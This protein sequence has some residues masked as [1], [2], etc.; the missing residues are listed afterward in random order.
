MPDKAQM[1]ADI[2]RATKVMTG[3][4]KQ[5]YEASEERGDEAN[6]RIDQIV[7]CGIATWTNDNGDEVEDVFTGAESRRHHLVTGILA[8]TLAARFQR[9]WSRP[10][11]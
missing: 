6:F 10:P 8:D 2:A 11:E 5:M 7:I 4:V 3:L 9:S 1:D